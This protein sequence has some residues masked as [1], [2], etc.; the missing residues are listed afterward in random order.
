[1][2]IANYLEYIYVIRELFDVSVWDKANKYV[3]EADK[4]KFKDN[5]ER[6]AL[7]SD[8]AGLQQEITRLRE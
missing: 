7:Q 3:H 1:M 5:K 4:N 8:I 6:I 2:I